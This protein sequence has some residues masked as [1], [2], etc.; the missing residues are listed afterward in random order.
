MS[1]MIE[2][3][4]LEPQDAAREAQFTAIAQTAGGRLDFREVRRSH[5][6]A[7]CLTYDFETLTQAE[8]VAEELRQGGVH[9]EGPS[10]Y[11]P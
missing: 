7:L 8:S 6:T 3:F 5:G 4:C 10:D 11:G 1:Y 2:V 9:V